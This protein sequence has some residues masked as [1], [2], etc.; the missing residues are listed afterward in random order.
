MALVPGDD[1]EHHGRAG[2]EPPDQP[3]SEGRGRRLL[4]LECEVLAEDPAEH[5]ELADSLSFAF[6]ALLE[7]LTPEQ[8][9]V[10]LLRDVFD[11]PYDRIA[12]IVGKSEPAVRQSVVRARRHRADGRVAGRR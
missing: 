4:Q 5:A 8:R 1:R 6:L 7:R 3:P 12:E 11:Y 2:D 10:F 9:A